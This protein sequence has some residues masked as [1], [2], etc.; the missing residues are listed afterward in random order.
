M[1]HYDSVLMVDHSESAIMVDHWALFTPTDTSQNRV[2]W[3]PD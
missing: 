2:I 3:Q 1:D